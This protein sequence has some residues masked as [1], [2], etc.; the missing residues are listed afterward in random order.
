MILRGLVGG[1]LLFS[2]SFDTRFICY[3]FFFLKI[4]RFEIIEVTN[5]IVNLTT[6]IQ[7]ILWLTI[8][9]ILHDIS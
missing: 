9:G 6:A 8:Y 5:N 3:I 7:N 2:N 4:I 1:S